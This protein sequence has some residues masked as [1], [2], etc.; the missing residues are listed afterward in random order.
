[1]GRIVAGKS[2]AGRTVEV[3]D[4]QNNTGGYLIFTYAD[5]NRS[6]EVFDTWVQSFSDVEAYFDDLGWEVEWADGTR[7]EATER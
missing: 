2:Q 7:R 5:V 6:P 1:M 3:V 4:D